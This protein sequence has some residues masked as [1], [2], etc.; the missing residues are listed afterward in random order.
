[1]DLNPSDEARSDERQ[2]R[3]ADRLLRVVSRTLFSA[4]TGVVLMAS[5]ATTAVAQPGTAIDSRFA[6]L[7]EVRLHY[8]AAGQGEPVI[9]LHGYAQN[10]HMW[11]PLIAELA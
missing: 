9:L 8:L 11:R 6:D 3:S 5:I 1:M 4:L 10:S 2:T 7:D